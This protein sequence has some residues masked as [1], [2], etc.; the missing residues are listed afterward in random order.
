[1][2][3]ISVT[4]GGIF[5]KMTTGCSELLHANAQIQKEETVSAAGHASFPGG[6]FCKPMRPTLLAS[7]ESESLPEEADV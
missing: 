2:L 4:F 3:W 1:M 5:Q 6:P 7:M